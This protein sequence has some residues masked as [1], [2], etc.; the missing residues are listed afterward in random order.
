MALRIG[1]VGCGDISGI[2]LRNAARFP[3]LAL[4]ACASRTHARAEAAAAA[5]GIAARSVDDLIAS[6]DIDLVVNLTPPLAHVEVTARALAAGKHVYSEKPLGVDLAEA[7][8]LVAQATAA[9]LRLGVAPDTALGP[10][11]QTARRL[12]AEGAI[13][14]PLFGTAAFLGLGPEQF[15]PAPAFFYGRGGGPLMDMGPYYLTALVHILGPV[16]GLRAANLVQHPERRIDAPGMPAHGSVLPSDVATTVKTELGFAGGMTVDFTASWDCFASGQPHI[17]LHGSAGSLRLPNPDW[18]GGD[19]LI[20]ERPGAWRAIDTSAT[21]F[22]APNRTD[23]AGVPVADYRGLGIAEMAQAIRLGTVPRS[24]AA[25]AL[26]LAAVFDAAARSARDRT[27]VTDLP[28]CP[29]PL[30][31]TETD[32]AALLAPA[33]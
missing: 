21:V 28:G 32:A 9:G 25:L 19:L 2:Y 3:G 13:G 1:I 8:Q 27:T 30:P 4:T 29:V 7:A 11:I 16:T 26:H 17:E 18:F 5:H 24:D 20:A 12:V 6:D 23:E 15:H 33:A 14:T 10:A 31:L 22:G